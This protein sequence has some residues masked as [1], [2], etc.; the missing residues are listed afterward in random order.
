M[1]NVGVDTQGGYYGGG[2]FILFLI[3]ILLVLGIWG[4]G[5]CGYKK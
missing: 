1:G 5:F 3:L 4:Y 2:A